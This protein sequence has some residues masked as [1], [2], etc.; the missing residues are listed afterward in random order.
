[1]NRGH[2]MIV[3]AENG[4]RRNEL[5]EI[6]LNMLQAHS[7][8]RL[9][10]MEWIELDGCVSFRY[11]TAGKRLLTHRFHLQPLTPEEYYRLL[12]A[13]VETLDDCKHYMLR[14]E[15]CLLQE[16]CLFVG[17][18][19]DDV[20][21]AY[22]PLNDPNPEKG[23]KAGELLALAV[24]WTAHV[25]EAVGID[26]QRIL[27]E[28]E[29]G[30]SWSGL[31]QTL[32]VM[33]AH[34]EQS[35]GHVRTGAS[36]GWGVGRPKMKGSY[37][38]LHGSADVAATDEAWPSG[39]PKPYF[40]NGG[41]PPGEET[42]DADEEKNEREASSGSKRTVA[43]ALAALAIAF[44]WRFVYGSAP[45]RAGLLFSGLL[46]AATL[47]LLAAVWRKK[48]SE[49]RRM[50]LAERGLTE[51]DLMERGLTER[52]LME[53]DLTEH[54]SAEHGSTERD[55]MK[56]DLIEHDLLKHDWAERD[57]AERD[58]TAH[59]QGDNGK[60]EYGPQERG[61]MK[62]VKRPGWL[63]HPDKLGQ[64]ER[65]PGH[66]AW[67][68]AATWQGRAS[69]P[70]ISEQTIAD[71]SW[72]GQK[73]DA[74]ADATQWLGARSQSGEPP[75]TYWLE[76]K[77]G[78]QVERLPIIGE[79]T[80]IGRAEDSVQVVDRSPGISRIHLELVNKNGEVTVKDMG[81]RNGSTLNGEAMIPYKTYKLREGD[82]L[83]LAGTGGPVYEL[84]TG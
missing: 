21:I 81:S 71:H 25:R 73:A 35:G 29:G 63:E 13:I 76:R 62:R 6:E 54:D 28:L 39:T 72:I 84:K 4:I 66:F 11:K 32:Q 75:G 34:T 59:G 5:D 10:P 9:L 38:S 60:A 82:L 22:L 31:R 61:P 78:F 40:G 79:L 43:V 27:R 77:T 70:E 1:M 55:L 74:S 14:P 36:D 53:R 23:G 18:S 42:P 83:Q 80:R 17:E 46:T 15:G 24:R 69:E 64:M 20:G 30:E 19:V 44:I 67:K 52:D 12:L 41:W 3:D 16:H 50:E 7:I 56:R 68:D 37:E 33:A 65:V 8:P 57:P 51:R 47:G 2:E 26:H 45:D 49:P 58:G 48:R